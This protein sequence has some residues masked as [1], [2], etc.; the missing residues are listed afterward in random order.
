MSAKPADAAPAEQPVWVAGVDAAGTVVVHAPVGQGDDPVQVLAGRGFRSVGVRQA[1]RDLGGH[2]LVLTFGVVA[3][4]EEVGPLCVGLHGGPIVEHGGPRSDPGLVV[5][6]GE[7]PRRVQ[8]VAA[9]AVVTSAWGV[10]LTQFSDQ[11]NAPGQWGL[12]GGGLDPMELP[13]DAVAREVWEEAGQQVSEV[14]LQAIQSSHWVGRAPRGTLEDF[15]ALRIIYTAVC[16]EPIEPVV[17]DVGGTTSDARWVS[18]DAF[19]E[20]PLTPTWR[21]ILDD[22]LSR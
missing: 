20:L 22:V 4:S 8:R 10:L 7:V 19:A 6:P 3:A 11:T 1:A 2:R 12:P 5:R 14:R 18:T 21:S 16:A 15:H 17:H 13:Q 9:Y